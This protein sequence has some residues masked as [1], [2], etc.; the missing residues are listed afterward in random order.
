[1]KKTISKSQII[2]Y[3]KKNG[4]ESLSGEWKAEINGVMVG[5]CKTTIILY[6]EYYKFPSFSKV[7]LD[8]YELVF[9]TRNSTISYGRDKVAGLYY[10]VIEGIM[11]GM[12]LIENNEEKEEKEENGLTVKT[13]RGYLLYEVIDENVDYGKDWLKVYNWLEGIEFTNEKFYY[14]SNWYGS[15][16]GFYNEEKDIII[17]SVDIDDMDEEDFIE[18]YG[19]DKEKAENELEFVEEPILRELDGLHVEPENGRHGPLVIM[20]EDGLNYKCGR[21]IYKFRNGFFYKVVLK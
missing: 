20:D 16:G 21:G 14:F 5:L 10:K 8:N 7:S 1:M 11:M 13:G 9:E 2:N 4:T 6:D 18:A 3:I 17:P 19:I 12:G 15:V